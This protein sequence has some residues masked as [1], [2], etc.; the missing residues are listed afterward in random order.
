MLKYNHLR[1]RG[2]SG[3]LWQCLVMSSGQVQ[4]AIQ[5]IPG[6]ACLTPSDYS[7]PRQRHSIIQSPRGQESGCRTVK[8]SK[9]FTRSRTDTLELGNREKFPLPSSDPNSSG[10]RRDVRIRQVR[11]WMQCVFDKP[12]WRQNFEGVLL[13]LRRAQRSLDIYVS[14][15]AIRYWQQQSIR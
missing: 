2:F 15:T 6:P 5:I 13:F 7:H 9:L 1:L 3:Q 10:F 11:G 4:A 12:N 8:T 14:M